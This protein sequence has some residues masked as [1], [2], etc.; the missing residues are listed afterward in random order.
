MAAL[1]VMVLVV[2]ER[3]VWVIRAERTVG[4]VTSVTARNARCSHRR[5][6][7]NCT[8]YS[9]V[10]RYMVKDA[11]YSL[12]VNAGKETGHN[13]PTT[14]AEHQVRQRVKVIFDPGRPAT[15]FRDTL[16]EIYAAAIFFF[17][18]HLSL[19]TASFREPKSPT[20][21][22]IELGLNRTVGG[23]GEGEA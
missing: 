16:A 4:E 19:L 3:T 23:L 6:R 1:A 20:E 9:A 21:P 5:T 14:L 11:P 2:A 17:L 13:R 12:H 22:A 18:I 15:A 8:V 10:I 7:Y